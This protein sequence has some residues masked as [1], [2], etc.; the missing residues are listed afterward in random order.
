MQQAL[1]AVARLLAVPDLTYTV[2]CLH[3]PVLLH[4]AGHLVQHGAGNMQ[5]RQDGGGGSGGEN[6]TAADAALAVALVRV[7]DLA[8]HAYR[9]GHMLAFQRSVSSWTTSSDVIDQYFMVQQCQ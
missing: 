5:R 7:L 4:V 9:Q 1:A 3:R 8:P 2:A 6:P